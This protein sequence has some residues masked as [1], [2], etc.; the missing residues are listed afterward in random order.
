MVIGYFGVAFALLPANDNFILT[1]LLT[2]SSA[3]TTETTVGAT[4]TNF[5]ADLTTWVPR[6]LWARS[7]NDGTPL[8]E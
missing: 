1:E 2:V 5:T 7:G 8:R 6:E 3:N 4:S